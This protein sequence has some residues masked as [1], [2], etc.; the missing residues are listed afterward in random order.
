MSARTARATRCVGRRGRLGTARRADGGQDRSQL[1]QMLLVHA[2]EGA[3]VLARDVLVQGVH[4][5][6]KG[7]V[8]LQLAGPARQHHVPALQRAGL[9]LGEQARLADARLAAETQRTRVTLLSLVQNALHEA[10]FLAA[11][12]QS[13]FDHSHPPS[14][15]P[16]RAG[17][18][19]PS[20]AYDD[21]ERQ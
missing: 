14:V 13:G 12:Y 3:H 19:T 18:L 9:Q 6:G 2:L 8:A 5:K 20:A 4:E 10:K 1:R 7:Q 21:P 16:R 11:S 15:A 17:P